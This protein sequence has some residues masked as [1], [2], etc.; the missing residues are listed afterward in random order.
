MAW[1]RALDG[2]EVS[3]FAVDEAH[4]LSQWGHDFRPDYTRLR[5]FRQLLDNPLTIALT[6]TATPA[7]QQDIISQLGL[8]GG[9]MQIFHEGINRPNL[10]LGVVDLHGDDS[11]LDVITSEYTHQPGSTIVYF[12]LIKT[13]ERFIDRLVAVTSS[14]RAKR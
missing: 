8:T 1:I 14:P 7:V 13:L 10:R 2:V 5:Q 9:A 11:K 3:L 6:A 4:C 12:A